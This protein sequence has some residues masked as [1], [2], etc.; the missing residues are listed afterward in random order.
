M[1]LTVLTERA[2]LNGNVLHIAI[3][4]NFMELI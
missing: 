4:V 2:T 3:H 1:Y